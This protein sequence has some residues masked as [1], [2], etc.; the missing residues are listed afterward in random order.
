MKKAGIIISVLGLALLLAGC[1]KKPVSTENENSGKEVGQAEEKSIWSKA[2]DIKSAMLGGKKMEC[3]YK[4]KGAEG[5]SMEMKMQVQGKKFRSVT[6]I[7]GDKM[8][9]VSDG[10]AIYSWSEKTKKGTKFT[11]KCMEDLAKENPTEAGKNEKLDYKA[12]EE[13]VDANNDMVC[14]PT[15]SV[16]FSVPT[17]VVFEDGCAM[18]KQL[19]EMSD[20]FKVNLPEGVK[21]PGGVL[22]E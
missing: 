10:E 21:V 22:Q 9:S 8:I 4:Q 11:I 7:Q 1:G 2:E 13:L 18:L 17:D 20:K 14:K 5:E 19:Q 6:E 12:P 16:D 3:T 15:L